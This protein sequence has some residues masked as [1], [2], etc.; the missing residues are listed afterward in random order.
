MESMHHRWFLV[1]HRSRHA[2][3]RERFSDLD[4]EPRLLPL[5]R[6]LYGSEHL[7]QEDLSAESGLD[8]STIA[9][10]VRRLIELGYVTREPF[11]GD[12][13]AYRLRLTEKANELVPELDAAMEEWAAGLT[14]DFSED[15]I[16]RLD[17]YLQRMADRAEKLARHGRCGRT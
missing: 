7:R 11:P 17:G 1:V 3:L 15:E 12:R 10:G 6:R 4:V 14:A 8:K 9:R 5:L 16:R 13:R 2:F